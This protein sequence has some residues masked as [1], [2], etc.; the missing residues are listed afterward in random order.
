MKPQWFNATRPKD[1]KKRLPADHPNESGK[2][3]AEACCSRVYLFNSWN[4]ILQQHVTQATRCSKNLMFD[5]VWL[6]HMVNPL[7]N[8]DILWYYCIIDSNP[9]F[10]RQFHCWLCSYQRLSP[11]RVSVSVAHAKYSAVVNASRG[12]TMRSMVGSWGRLK[13]TEKQFLFFFRK[14]SS[15]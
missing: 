5:S 4:Q 3:Q 13:S 6:S 14:F 9:F 10:Q 1:P 11:L 7:V 8:I 2:I 12:V 15:R